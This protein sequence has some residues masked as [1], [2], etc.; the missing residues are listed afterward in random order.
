L[1][2][3]RR[4]EDVLDTWFSSAL[5]PFSTLGWPDETP[6]VQRYYPTDALVTGFDIIFFWVARMMMMGLHFMDAVPFNTVYIHA[7]VRDEKGQKMSKSKGNVIDPLELI[8]RYGADALRFTLTALAVQGR[9]VKMSESRVEGYRNFCTKLWNAAR[10]CRMNDALPVTGFDPATAS[11]PVNRWLVAKLARTI[12]EATDALATYRF[13]DYANSLYQ[14]TWA[15]FCDWY[16]EFVKPLLMGGSAA[17][18]TE[19]RAVAGWA[20][21]QILRLLHPVIPFVT[22][23]L[24]AQMTARGESLLCDHPWP[25]ASKLPV[26]QAAEAE[27]DGAVRLIAT[28]RAMRVDSN[29]PPGTKVPL[30]LRGGDSNSDIATLVTRHRALIQSLARVETVEVIAGEAPKGSVQSVCDGTTV[31]LP[32]AEIIDVDA[33]RIRLSKELGRL[34]SEIE[35]LNRKLANPSFLAKAPAEV[36][37]THRDRLEAAAHARV[38]LS[39]AA[40]KLAEL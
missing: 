4:D 33:E 11:E 30:K 28:I 2:E 7:L 19:T 39:E 23:E 31:I 12:E 17:T 14:F 21:D 29:V 37:A 6:E 20:F 9:D 18:Q 8:D 22:E 40:R 35:R 32:L 5:W 1:V 34:E 3:L 15:T 24:H 13:N 25:E 10:F 38:K 27:I 26:D 16:L 36:V